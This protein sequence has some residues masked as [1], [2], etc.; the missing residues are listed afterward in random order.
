[1]AGSCQLSTRTPCRA[2]RR[3]P[4]GRC[5]GTCRLELVRVLVGGDPGDRGGM[6]WVVDLLGAGRDAVAS[7]VLPLQAAAE[8][9]PDQAAASAAQRDGVLVLV[10][11][12]GG[13]GDG[14]ERDLKC[15]GIDHAL[16]LIHISEPTR[17]GMIS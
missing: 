7:E 3:S 13:R 14:G 12:V 2:P 16:S 17:L 15:L 5:A 10:D 1:M 9:D 8:E 11:L 4:V 6:T